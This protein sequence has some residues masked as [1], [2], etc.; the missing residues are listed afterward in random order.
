MRQAYGWDELQ[1]GVKSDARF[2]GFRYL[3]KLTRQVVSGSLIGT[4]IGAIPG[5]SGTGAIV[6][7]YQQAKLT[8]KTPE[9]FGRG[10]EEGIAAN[11]SAGNASQAG[12]LVSHPRAWR[13]PA[14]D[15]MVLLLGALLL[16]GF[17]PGPLLLQS[18]PE[19]L[20][21]TVA[22][23]LGAGL[24]T[25]LLGWR[26]QKVLLRLVQLD[27]RIVFPLAFLLTLIGVLASP[28][29]VRRACAPRL[30]A[31]RLLHASLRLLHPGGGGW[32]VVGR[33]VREQPAAGNSADERQRHRFRDAPMDRGNSQPLRGSA[34]L[35]DLQQYPHQQEAA[36]PRPKSK[37]LN[38]R[39][40]HDSH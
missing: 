40:I 23:L 39:S 26:V 14:S 34:G 13:L 9:K 17:V 33:R 25:I 8:S 7:A 27:R 12:E 16:Q 19:L 35:R 37:S 36:C 20:Y 1:R 21:A 31:C 22:G 3:G 4:L 6:M 38:H 32:T 5:M 15:T 30:R 29:R 24:I 18:S 11:E 2:P 28:I 10:S